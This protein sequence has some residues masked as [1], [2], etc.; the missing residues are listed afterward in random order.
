MVPLGTKMKTILVVLSGLGLACAGDVARNPGPAVRDSAGIRIVENMAPA[1][2]GTPAWTVDSVP[3]VTIGR[4]GSDPDHELYGVR[5]AVRTRAGTIVVASNKTQELRF[6]GPDG[7]FLKRVGGPGKGPGEFAHLASVHRFHGDSLIAMDYVQSRLS[8]LTE[9]GAFVRSAVLAPAAMGLPLII[10]PLGDGTL[11][12][13]TRSLVPRPSEGAGFIREPSVYLAYTP[14]GAVLDTL[15]ILPDLEVYVG[16][17]ALEPSSS[18]PFNRWAGVAAAGQYFYYGPGSDFE[19][20]S[21]TETGNLT[22]IVRWNLEQRPVGNEDIEAYRQRELARSTDPGYRRQFERALAG[23]KHPP[24]MPAHRSLEIDTEG[25]LWV[26]SF[27]PSDQAPAVWNVFDPEGVW[28]AEIELPSG[29]D[30]LDIG[31][32]YVLGKWTGEMD[33]EEV[34]VHR[35]HR[36]GS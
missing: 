11:V 34:R 14:D 22:R 3:V 10:G 5:G 20:Q 25:Y 27:R 13:V 8:V 18:S 21:Y 26:E 29:L 15:G 6:F 36:T 24:F 4:L 31:G 1:W 2:A 9:D 7:G 16:T 35:L 28:L 33:V 12:T 30:V 19:V 32:D 23:M 17:D